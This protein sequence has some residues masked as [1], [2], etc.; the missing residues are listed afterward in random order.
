M[1]WVP[2]AANSAS[3]V[4]KMRL[5]EQN[6]SSQAYE[7]NILMTFQGRSV[8][9]DPANIHKGFSKNHNFLLFK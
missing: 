6:E 3:S 2:R 8:K 1:V 5:K 9:V 4:G 7:L